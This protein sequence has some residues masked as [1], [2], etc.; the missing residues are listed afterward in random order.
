MK[1]KLTD[2]E[3]TRIADQRPWFGRGRRVTNEDLV[4]DVAEVVEFTARR[5]WDANECAPPCCPRAFLVQTADERFIYLESWN[6]LLITNA[7]GEKCVAHCAAASKTLL[8]FETAGQIVGPEQYS[9]RDALLN[10]SATECEWVNV[11]D[12]PSEFLQSAEMA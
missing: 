8:A 5:W 4:A 10:F 6:V 1:R 11:A 9:V 2:E 7:L 12:L 3:R